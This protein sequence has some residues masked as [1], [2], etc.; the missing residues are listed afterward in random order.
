MNE[1]AFDLQAYLAAGVE[2]VVK[3]ALRSTLRSRLFT[4]LREGDVLMEDHA[5][6]C[7]LFERRDQVEALL[8]KN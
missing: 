5:G 3:S 4:A 6:G 1:P 2:T 8:S 7:V